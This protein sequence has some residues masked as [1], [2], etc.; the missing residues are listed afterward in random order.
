MST[1]YGSF[2]SVPVS[3]SSNTRHGVIRRIR[4][5]SLLALCALAGIGST[6]CSI[7]PETEELHEGELGAARQ[8]ILS[9][10][11]KND[12]TTGFYDLGNLLTIDIEIP[13][14]DWA[15]LLD[16]APAGG[17]CNAAY[18]GDRFTWFDASRVKISGT[19]S[20]EVDYSR[21]VEIRKKSWCSSW[22]DTK[23]SLRIKFKDDVGEAVEDKIGT[24]KL[25]LNN[26]QGD[27]SFLRQC[28]G[29]RLFKD[30]GLPYSRC[31]FALVRVNGSPVGDGLYVNVEPFEERYVDNNF[32]FNKNGNLYEFEIG[33]DFSTDP[34]IIDRTEWKGFSSIG[35]KADLILAGQR[36][37]ADD[38]ANVID[39]DQFIKYWAMEILIGHSDSYTGNQ[40]NIY[41]YN[42]VTAV[43]AP[44]VSDVNFK[45]APMG[46]DW[47]L[48]GVSG[49][50]TNSILAQKAA[51][52]PAMM[53]RLRRQIYAYLG[54]VFNA[55]TIETVLDPWIRQ[56]E[57]T[58]NSIVPGMVPSGSAQDII[59][60]LKRT[61]PSIDLVYD[62]TAPTTTVKIAGW[63][64][65]CAHR[66]NATAGSDGREVDHLP[67]SAGSSDPFRFDF[68][69]SSSKPAHYRIAY[70]QSGAPYTYA[71]RADTSHTIAGGYHDVYYG[72]VGSNTDYPQY[73]AL[74]PHGDGASRRYELQ[75]VETGLCLHFSG[76]L[77]TSEGNYQVYQATCDGSEK[78][79]VTFVE[80][81][82]SCSEATAVDLGSPGTN[83]TVPSDGCVMVR[84]N[85]PSWWGSSRTMQ[86][87]NTT[88]AGYPI[89]FT[90]SNACTGASGAGTY[91]GDWQS[92]YFGPTGSGCA[93]LIDL[94]GSG[95]GNITLR[96]YGL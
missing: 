52:D 76:G 8:A 90:W 25:M 83:V 60:V 82:T 4:T 57:S 96:Y 65:E 56:M 1:R 47:I 39:L 72:Q 84:N 62:V 94:Q 55:K 64:N 95:S 21:K 16:E 50:Q 11:Q 34:A 3:I 59:D 81:D 6:S 37:E 12:L 87:Q 73:F 43:A 19:S 51:A 69:Q 40:N 35:N 63:N 18:I 24:R 7:Q 23:P 17:R 5:S 53:E 36:I 29:Y 10:A 28:V 32:N 92:K 85:Y 74:I 86:L 75:S 80:V 66:G 54:T 33:E 30:A 20:T 31:N 68:T 41:V 38:I 77:R 14:D 78:N 71:M 89:P 61:R 46:I 88:A 27:S 13:P 15:A 58:A 2:V 93:T 48:H 9:D 91:T 26:S 49:I 79:L 45:F 67:C 70:M 44:G 22:S 42:D